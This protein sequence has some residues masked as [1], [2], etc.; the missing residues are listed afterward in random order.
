MNDE[1]LAGLSPV[2]GGDRAPAE[3]PVDVAPLAAPTEPE[4][5]EVLE[6][7]IQVDELGPLPQP[8]PPPPAP[9]T[10]I[11]RPASRRPSPAAALADAFDLRKFQDRYRRAIKSCADLALAIGVLAAGISLVL[12]GAS[13]TGSRLFGLVMAALALFFGLTVVFT[14]AAVGYLAVAVAWNAIAGVVGALFG[15]GQRPVR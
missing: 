10:V 5:D 14:G 9:T 4:A 3:E 1:E 15:V 11:L 7:E 13:A 12:A 6:D 8:A 2:L